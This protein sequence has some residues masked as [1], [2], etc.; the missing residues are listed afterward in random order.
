MIPGNRVREIGAR[1]GMARRGRVV[2]GPAR[3]G[4]VREPGGGV[5]PA[6]GHLPM[7]PQGGG[8]TGFGTAGSGDVW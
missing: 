2:H 4:K 1:S 7:I 6:S 5:K 8:N 3:L